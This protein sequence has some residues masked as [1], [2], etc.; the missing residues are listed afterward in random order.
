MSQNLSKEIE[1][2]SGKKF[3][4][5]ISYDKRVIDAIVELKPV[6]ET[7]SKVV[8]EIKEIFENIEKSLKNHL[9]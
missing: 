6:I 5:K 1:K 4:G 7:D 9:C 3:L 2:W 8:S